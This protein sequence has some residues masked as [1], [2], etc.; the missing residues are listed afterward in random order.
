V[1][2]I[3]DNW[4]SSTHEFFIRTFSSDDISQTYIEALNNKEHMK[5]S[6][7]NLDE[8]SEGT[9]RRFMTEVQ[10]RGGFL[11]GIF[12]KGEGKNLGTV[13]ILPIGRDVSM[14]FLI[15]PDYASAGVLT[16]VLRTLLPLVEKN[17]SPNW[18]HIG[19]HRENL[20][21]QRVALKNGFR[22][23]SQELIC[24]MINRPDFAVSLEHV[25]LLKSNSRKDLTYKKELTH[26]SIERTS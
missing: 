15:F 18:L 9:A 26:D 20:A 7:Q 2:K 22:F 13:T 4:I 1:K 12:N 23:I 8:H 3:S 25:H 24:K 5:Y 19:T 6:R 10:E 17:C 16:K 14:G 21:M 11:L